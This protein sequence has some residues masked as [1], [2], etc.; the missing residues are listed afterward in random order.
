M[1]ANAQTAVPTFSAAQ[2]LTADQQNQSA[3]TGIPVFASTTTRNAA[4]GGS[5][6]TL[7][8]G[9]LCYVEGTGLQSYNGTTWVTW[10][11]APSTGGLV[12]ISG[13]TTFSASSSVTLDSVFT[14]T[15]RNYKILLNYTTSGSNSLVFRVRAAG[16]SISTNTYNFQYVAGDGSTA[17]AGRTSST[18]S[19]TVG[20]A[21]GGTY[22]ASTEI[23]VYNPQ[24]ATPTTV[25][26]VTNTAYTAYTTVYS[27]VWSGNNSNA[28]A[29]DGFELLSSAST[30]TG[31]Y[32]V[33]GLAT[34]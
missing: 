27:A 29:Y 31:N 23:T 5:N 28:T 19:I 26:A 3:R 34:A 17:A 4:F 25:V 33:Y 12:R 16:S 2:I 6:K 24:V 32:T 10:G 30:I 8:E 22:N 9:Q 18:S 20:N 15:Y 7:A 21:T 1:G 13:E 11:T 14:S